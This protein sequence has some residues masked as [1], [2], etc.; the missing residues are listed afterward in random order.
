M[1]EE[2]HIKSGEEVNLGGSAEERSRDEQYMKGVFGEFLS[3]RDDFGVEMNCLRLGGG[4]VRNKRSEYETINKEGVRSS[5][6]KAK[7]REGER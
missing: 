4:G 5:L 7:R 2:E 3:V 6:R 1:P